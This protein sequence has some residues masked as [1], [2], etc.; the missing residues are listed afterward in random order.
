MKNILSFLLIFSIMLVYSCS[1]NPVTGKKQISLMSE[2]Q[3]LALGKQSD[4]AIIGQYG[5]YEDDKLQ[6]FINEKG[7]AMG[8]ISH[9]DKLEY[10]FRILNT[11]VV[12]AFAVPG[13]Y[14]YFTR[15]I[16][17]HFNN[18]AEF[19]GVLGHEIGH[20]TSKHSSRQYTNQVFAQL[21]LIAGMILSPEFRQFGNEA[22]QATQL[23]MLKFSR[24]HESESD[25]L[26]VEYSTKIGYDAH[27][28]D[29]FFMT[30]KRLSGDSGQSLPT[31]LSTHPDPV[32]RYN[33]V[34]AYADDFQKKDKTTTD[35]QVNRDSYLRMIDGLIYG[36]DPKEGYIEG[37]KFYHPVMK[38]QYTLP[39][40]WQT[41]NT[42]SQV[43]M[44]EKEGKA[45]MFLG[46]SQ[47]SSLSAA[48]QKDITDNK[49]SLV[50]QNN[51]TLGGN[52]AMTAYATQA[53]Q[54]QDG[55]TVNLA[56]DL[57]YIQYGGAIYSFSGVTYE[58]TY[59]T[60]RPVFERTYTSFKKLSDPSKLNRMPEKIKI[61]SVSSTG[62]LQ[63]AFNKLKVPSNRQ[64]ELSIV[65][66]ME[67]KD[68]VK[69]GQLI[70]VLDRYN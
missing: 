9:R 8:A 41:V 19:A 34:H 65:N 57:C 68:Q 18:E 21:G 15:G 25:K 54:A 29:D 31:F 22:M 39:A 24:D 35:Y 62:T 30:L 6:K 37:G 58:N 44:G 2:A 67:L 14:V 64:N 12:N 70:K 23:L 3:E 5:M 52:P 49:L 40:N 36:D 59:S 61:A 16:M 42:P 63:S 26:G 33:K 45:A 4:P 20:I 51:R 27:Y 17:A 43:Q 13:G 53:Q 7:K 11:P 60:Y 48:L 55:S 38:F 32:D 50:K 1:I 46:L 69:A 56:V 47:E 66:G 28:M 10:N